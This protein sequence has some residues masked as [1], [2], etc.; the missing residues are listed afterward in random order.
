MSKFRECG[1]CTACCTAL[2]VDEIEKPAGEPCS[3]LCS[4]GRGCAIYRTR[5][6]ACRTFSCWWL[7]ELSKDVDKM[8]KRKLHRKPPPPALK[9]EDRPDRSGV[10]LHAASA[11]SPFLRRC[12]VLP[13]IAREV[14]PGA[15]DAPAGQAV[16][17][18]AARAHLVILTRGEERTLVGPADKVQAAQAFMAGYRRVV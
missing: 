9:P 10:L 2:S 7:A 6:E 15:F 4:S 11:D 8:F 16:V 17:D 3:Q 12:G 5:P 13:I 18:R 1:P 14:Q